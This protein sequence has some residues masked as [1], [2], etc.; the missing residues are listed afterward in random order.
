MTRHLALPLVLVLFAC[1]DKG[2]A[3]PAPADAERGLDGA[4]VDAEAADAPPDAPVAPDGAPADA[5][6]PDAA[7]DGAPVDAL[8]PT[9]LFLFPDGMPSNACSALVA[10][11]AVASF[12]YPGTAPPS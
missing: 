9:D 12:S 11:P 3:Q 6:P 10:G 8:P 1:D 4:P 2:A 7:A 5:P